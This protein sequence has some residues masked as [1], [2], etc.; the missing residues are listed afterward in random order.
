MAKQFNFKSPLDMCIEIQKSTKEQLGVI[1]VVLWRFCNLEGSLNVLP[2][3]LA[4]DQ[5]RDRIG[6]QPCIGVS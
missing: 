2:V 3:E 4:R 6:N 5:D 1:D